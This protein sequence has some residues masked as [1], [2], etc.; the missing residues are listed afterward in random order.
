[1]DPFCLK[2]LNQAR[3]LRQAAIHLTDLA[4][5]RDRVI[6]QN[7]AVAGELGAAIAQTFAAG[8]SRLVTANGREFFLNLHQPALRLV[9]VGA[10]HVSQTL[11]PMAAKLGYEVEIID[12]RTGFATSARFPETEVIAEWPQDVLTNR[13]LDRYSALAA[14]SHDPKIDDPALESALEAGCFYIGALGS[15]KTHEKRIERLRQKGIDDDR[16]R[17]VHAPI[18][19]AI[20]AA[21]PQEIAVAILAEVVQA[22]RVGSIAEEARN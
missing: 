14:L 6:L 5:G 2:K 4:D 1:M 18:G 12:P 10:V 9:L 19:L 21:N 11:A 3:R 22:F 20:G 16:L 13:P 15:R 8:R 17:R 7:D